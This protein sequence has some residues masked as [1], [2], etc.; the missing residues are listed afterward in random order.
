MYVFMHIGLY[1]FVCA[2]I[3]LKYELY[4]KGSSTIDREKFKDTTNF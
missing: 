4:T 2:S 3:D 1:M